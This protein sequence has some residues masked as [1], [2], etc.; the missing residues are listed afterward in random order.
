MRV[1]E[2]ANNH[3]STKY[4]SK[5]VIKLS[6][7][8]IDSQGVGFKKINTFDRYNLNSLKISSVGTLPENIKVHFLVNL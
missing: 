1:R 2:E 8:R 7:G 5:Q 6:N 4:I 3:M